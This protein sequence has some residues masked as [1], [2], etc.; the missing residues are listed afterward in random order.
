MDTLTPKQEEL[1]HFIEAYQMENGA[2]PTIREMC[3]ALD[4]SSDNSVIKHLDAL[5]R[6]GFISRRGDIARGIG[7]LSSVRNRLEQP[8]MTKIPILGSIPAGG[9]VLSEEHVDGYLSLGED[10]V[11]KPEKSF[12]LRVTGDSMINAGILAG[13]FVVASTALK[14][15][16]GD[17]V[18]ALVDGMN[19]VKT[20]KHN[21][22]TGFHLKPE[23]P[24]YSLIYPT[25]DLQIQG[26]VTAV[27]RHY[28]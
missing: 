26:V 24:K 10:L 16:T 8:T 2:S 19:T 21:T 22:K 27:I 20:F 7:L 28:R 5:E 1:L 23:N 13:D 3:Q 14:A 6:K 9:P 25:E 11:S 12:V 15:K 17:I 4:V 18:I